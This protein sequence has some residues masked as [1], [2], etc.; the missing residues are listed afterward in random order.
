M[1]LAAQIIAATAV[2][3]VI[4]YGAVSLPGEVSFISSIAPVCI[5]MGVPIEPL[6]LLI[7][8]FFI[9]SG[10]VHAVRKVTS[11]RNRSGQRQTP[12]RVQ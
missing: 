5:A 4:S 2:A 10:A 7:A 11:P 6:V 8:G 3:S 9:L 12:D 1:M